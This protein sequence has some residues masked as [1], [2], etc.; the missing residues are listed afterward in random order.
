MRNLFY[1]L[2]TPRDLQSLY[3]EYSLNKIFDSLA[4]LQRTELEIEHLSNCIPAMQQ[5]KSAMHAVKDLLYEILLVSSNENILDCIFETLTSDNPTEVQ[6]HYITVMEVLKNVYD[7][8]GNV[9][10]LRY[11][12]FMSQLQKKWSKVGKDLGSKAKVFFDYEVK[13]LQEARI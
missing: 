10:S 6:E 4:Y 9:H 11:Q 12:M 7:Q 2:H 8:L 13:K 3:W 5:R 1:N